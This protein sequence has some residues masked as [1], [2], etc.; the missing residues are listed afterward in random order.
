M[1]SFVLEEDVGRWQSSYI[2]AF[3]LGAFGVIWLA[4]AVLIYGE[5]H[6][7]WFALAGLLGLAPLMYGACTLD[8]AMDRRRGNFFQRIVGG[9]LLDLLPA[10]WDVLPG[11]LFPL[12]D[13]VDLILRAPTDEVCVV[14][15]KTWGRWGGGFWSRQAL[16]QARRQWVATS[17]SYAVIWLPYAQPVSKL[18][19]DGVV[20]VGGDATRFFETIGGMIETSETEAKQSGTQK[21]WN[22]IPHTD[23]APAVETCWV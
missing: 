14:M 1:R 12:A 6:E 18:W 17:A 3:S 13:D 10:E 21:S 8:R 4:V 15:I 16:Q 19:P 23:G 22:E 11:W 9:R 20:M 2:S 7:L 5:R